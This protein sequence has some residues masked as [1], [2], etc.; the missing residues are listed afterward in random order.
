L[1]SLDR[2][3]HNSLN[4]HADGRGIVFDKMTSA[5]AVCAHEHPL[6]QSG[7]EKINGHKG[8]AHRHIAVTQLLTK[9]EGFSAQGAVAMGGNRVAY[10]AGDD[11]EN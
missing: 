1:L 6:V 3:I 8:R 2:F 9:Q 10:D 5:K 11:H 4:E 7:S